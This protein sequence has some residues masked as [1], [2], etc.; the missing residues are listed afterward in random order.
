MKLRTTAQRALLLATALG[1]GVLMAQPARTDLG[2]REY[3]G[4]CAVCHGKT[5]KGDGAYADMLRKSATDLTT[6]A[7]RNGGIFPVA[8]AY[9][10][11]EGSGVGHGTR[12][13]PIWG[14]DYNV[15]AAE[16]YMDVPYDPQ[17]YVRT[18]ILA[19]IEYLNRIQVK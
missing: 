3:D 5:G 7:K 13:M 4:N 11:I 12:D 2:K 19:L 15:K 1:C 18:R 9:E 10:V 8:R 17:V 6:M 16:Y 14:Q